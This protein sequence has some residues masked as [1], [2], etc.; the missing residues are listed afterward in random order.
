MKPHITQIHQYMLS[1]VPPPIPQ[2]PPR[3]PVEHSTDR[4]SEG[5]QLNHQNGQAAAEGEFVER[6]RV[7]RWNGGLG[8]LRFGFSARFR[9][10]RRVRH[11]PD[12]RASTF[13][14]DRILTYAAVGLAIAIGLLLLKKLLKANGYDVGGVGK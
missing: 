4:E 5:L 9:T 2:F 1:K 11:E 14:G 6:V 13:G 12:A 7:V 10:R 8:P 3:T